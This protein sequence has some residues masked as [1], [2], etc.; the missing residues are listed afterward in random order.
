MRLT[1]EQ[2]RIIRDTTHEVFGPDVTV[3]LFGSRTDDALRGGDIDLL[4]ES[5]RPIED[6]FHKGLELG[7]KLEIRLGE[8][9]IDILVV[10]PTVP[11]Q[12][13]HEE[14]RRSGVPL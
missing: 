12:P 3:S 5:D 11:P 13:I 6:R 2:A 8:Q 14:A 7:A 1:P 9:R 10:D 4:V